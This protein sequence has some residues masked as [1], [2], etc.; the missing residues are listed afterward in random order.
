VKLNQY[1]CLFR[2]YASCRSYTAKLH[3]IEPQGPALTAKYI[4]G[5]K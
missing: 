5:S 3:Y 1:K 2:G 4:R